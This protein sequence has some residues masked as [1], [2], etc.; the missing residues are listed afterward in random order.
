MAQRFDDKR[1][2]LVGDPIPVAERVGS[3]AATGSFSASTNGILVYRGGGDEPYGRAMWFDRQGKGLGT[4]VDRGVP[5]GLALSPDGSRAA[6]NLTKTGQVVSEDLRLLDFARGTDTRFTFGHGI[7]VQPVWSPDGSKI[8]FASNRDGAYNLYNK[9]TSGIKDEELLLKSGY[10][11]FPTSW[12]SDGRFLLYSAM[13]PK[14]NADL[15]VLQLEGDR[16]QIPF[17]R[18]E[19]NESDGHFSPDMH[20][21]AYVSDESGS[22]EIYVQGFSNT[23]GASAQTGGKW[24]I[25]VGGGMGPRWR[26]DGKELYYRAPDGKVMAVEVTTDT[27][28]RSGTPK[29]LFHAPSNLETFLTIPLPNWDVSTDGNRFLLMTSAEEGTPAPFTVVLNWQAGLK[30]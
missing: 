18:T 3:Y 6:V 26:R 13:D 16:K 5:R 7:N 1:L 2:E 29:P 11:K 23:S 8:I 4:V 22:N 9:A 24:Q 28:F 14:T 20:W 10:D 27:V 19:F 30:K 12:S 17:L 25:S 21:I 15:W